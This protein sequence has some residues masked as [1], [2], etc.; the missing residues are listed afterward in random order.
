MNAEDREA[1]ALCDWFARAYSQY[2]GK[3]VHV[4]NEYGTGSRDGAYL[5]K[6]KKRAR[7]GSVKG[8]ADYFL[9]VPCPPRS[10]CGLWLELKAP[11]GTLKADQRAFLVSVCDE[12]G[13]G[14]GWSWS[15]AAAIIEDYLEAG[16]PLGR[17]MA[18]N[19]PDA[20]APLERFTLAGK[21]RSTRV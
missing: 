13:A 21:M 5:G 1:I 20:V 10:Q 9:A 14:V 12:Y 19:G 15:A 8:V 6:L 2:A 3:L 7:M 11:G 4:A 18:S 16:L 17:V